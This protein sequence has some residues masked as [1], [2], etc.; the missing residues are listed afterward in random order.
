VRGFAQI[1]VFVDDSPAAARFW[2]EAL[3][4][5]HRLADGGA[6]VEPGFAQLFFH[7]VDRETTAAGEEKNPRGAS[8]VVYLAV[9]DFDAAR[10][11]LLA[12][13]CEPGGGRS[14]SRAAGASAS[15]ATPTARSGGSTGDERFGLTRACR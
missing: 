5:P 4:A 8:A 12:A 14:R 15:S 1:V 2:A 3:D 9:E 13:G 6:L 10:E 11:R 7:P